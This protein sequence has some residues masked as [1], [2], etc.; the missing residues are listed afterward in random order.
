MNGFIPPKKKI[1]R[2]KINTKKIT[3]CESCGAYKNCKNGKLSYSGNG[4]KGI[5]IIG[6]QVS[7]REDRDG[8]PF[9]D[10]ASAYMREELSN[11]GID[12]QRDCWSLNAVQCYTEKAPTSSMKDGCKRRMDEV[13]KEL[14]P[15]KILLLGGLATDMFLQERIQ[16]SRIGSGM[17]ERFMGKAIP[18]QEYGCWVI[19]NYHPSFVLNA[20][21]EKRK[22]LKK[23]NNYRERKGK[24]LWEQPQLIKDDS[25]RIKSLYFKKYLKNILVTEEFKAVDYISK[26]EYINNVT[27]AIGVMRTLLKEKV[28]SMDYETTSL[29]PYKSDSEILCV[30]FA[31]HEYA[32]SFP[33]FNENKVF[34]RIYKKLLTS[35][36]INLV[37]ANFGF[38][39]MWT[40]EKLGFAITNCY[41]DVVLGAH[42][43]RPTIEKVTNLK[44]NAYI[45]NGVLGYDANVE[46]YIKGRVEKDPYSLN[47]LKELPPKTVG[48]YNAEDSLHT[49]IIAYRQMSIIENDPKM[50]FI[51]KLYMKAQRMYSE[52]SFKG[53]PIDVVQLN[54]NEMKLEETLITLEY[55]IK[56]SKEVAKW[57]QVHP[58]ESF[59]YN[60]NTQLSELFF[61]IL[62]HTTNRKTNSG[63]M[64]INKDVLEELSVK[65]E[66]AS[67]LTEYKKV[68]KLLNTDLA[69]IKRYVCNNRIHPNVGVAVASTGRSNSSSP[70]FQNIAGFELALK[71]IKSC[72]IAEE[73]EEFLAYDYKS[74]EVYSSIGISKDK[75]MIKE[76]EDPNE[77]S[78]T[79]MTQRFF[80][81]DLEEAGLYIMKAKGEKDLSKDAVKQ[82]IKEE[83]RQHIKS[84][85]F[86]LQYGGSA[87]RIYT[88]L[89]E[90]KF[91]DYHLAWFRHKGYATEQK[92]RDLC[93]KV[94]EY[95]WDRYKMLKEYIDKTWEEYLT[96]GYFYSKF[97]FKYSGILSKTFVG[98]CNSQG[99]GFVLA[100]LGNLKLWEIMKEKGYKSSIKLTVHD[101][102]E[103]S[104]DAQEFFE[105]GL[106]Q[107]IHYAMETYV[108]RKVRWLA[109]PLKVDAE[110]Y[111][112]N[113]GTSCKRVTWEDRYTE[114]NEEGVRG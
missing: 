55:K 113:W 99:S 72:M 95:Y 18:D 74:L 109:L 80:G 24:A 26:C 59:N 85:N 13:I 33:I 25:F 49:Q 48:M 87:N 5:L 40:R 77:D 51:F 89:F 29:L 90:E 36:D 52:M 27:D 39:D 4:D 17:P 100:L 8:A 64:S 35:E 10:I 110:Y 73:G 82:F 62:G 75:I 11:I 114:E 53:T 44:V 112:K 104:V 9:T 1:N 91:K 63:N 12:I 7:R 69:G 103:F 66:L 71:M 70:N 68:Y 31:T 79:L 6:G 3:L 22:I 78:H 107:D 105:G 20:L 76:L 108:N 54:K 34:M 88:T 61:E 106:E 58:K 56:N 2:K 81:E 57:Y 41:W 111:D 28:L 65:S 19:I 60:S 102:T 38:E 50:N 16:K 94:Y 93:K 97:G 15:K 84:A 101:S 37:I 21:V 46:P 86:A 45:T 98:N 43:I 23:Y 92:L 83:M 32:Y 14:S 47:R 96:K 67:I 30:S 42:I